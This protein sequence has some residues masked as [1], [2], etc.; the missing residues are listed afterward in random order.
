MK[1]TPLVFGFL[2]ISIIDAFALF[3]PRGSTMQRMPKIR[4]DF[5][6]KMPHITHPR[7][8]RKNENAPLTIVL[9]DKRDELDMRSLK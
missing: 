3:A 5:L 4:G 1:T 7:R 9:F 6:P 8:D 2:R